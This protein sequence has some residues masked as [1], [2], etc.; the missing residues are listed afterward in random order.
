MTTDTLLRV[1]S[2]VAG[3]G[4]V[5]VLRR[6]SLTLP[7]HGV[8]CLLGANGAGKTTL[9]RSIMGVLPPGEGRIWFA[10]REGPDAAAGQ[11]ITGWPTH[12]IVAGGIAL[13]P[14]N[15]MVFGTLSVLDNLK[16]GSLAR[17][18]KTA[19][20][21]DMEQML[22]RFP[23]LKDRRHQR[24]GTLSGGE[25][26]MLAIAR[27]LMSRPGLLLMDEPSL[28]LAPMVVDE[29]FEM[30]SAL[31]AGGIG[32]LLVEQNI[33]MALKVARHVCFLEHGKI[34]S[35]EPGSG[36]VS[37]DEVYRSFFGGASSGAPSGAAAGAA[38]GTAVQGA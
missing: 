33:R 8:T 36:L 23:R 25:Q 30:V 7:R 19:I 32:I 16:V 3:Y 29:V 11:D 22:E 31:S 37:G 17:R 27:A 13:V 26:Q 6:A 35:V 14:E 10:G 18:D 12:R 34:R 2:L 5:E 21:E 4:K 1:E 9:L 28:G 24:A 15:R 20:A 38:V